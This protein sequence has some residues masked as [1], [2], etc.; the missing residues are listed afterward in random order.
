MPPDEWNEPSRRNRPTLECIASTDD[1]CEH[2]RVSLSE[3][4]E[5]APAFG[6]LPKERLRHIK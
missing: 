1:E 3:R 5:Q 2:L 6:Q 4:R